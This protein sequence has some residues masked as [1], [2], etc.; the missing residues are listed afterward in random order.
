ML[1]KKGLKA[2]RNL[3]DWLG[4]GI[5]LWENNYK[6]AAEWAEKKF[7]SNAAVIGVVV[8]LGYCLNLTDSMSFEILRQGYELLKIRCESQNIDL[9]QNKKSRNSDDIVQRNLDCAVIEQVHD[10]NKQNGLQ[11]FD[12]VRGIFTEGGP[13]YLG[14]AFFEKTHIQLCIRNPNCIKGYFKPAKK[15]DDFPNP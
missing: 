13:P 12:S 11:E 9:P 15:D 4:N 7:N 8:D 6:R 3:Y 5:Y 10:Y 2:S 1:R 14:S